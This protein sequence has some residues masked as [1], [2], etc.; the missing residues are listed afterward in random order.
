MKSEKQRKIK[1]NEV[2]FTLFVSFSPLECH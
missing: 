1:H 2:W